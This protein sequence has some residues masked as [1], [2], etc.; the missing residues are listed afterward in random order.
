MPTPR[1]TPPTTAP[2]GPPAGPFNAANIGTASDALVGILSAG[3]HPATRPVPP[4]PGLG[5]GGRNENGGAATD[6]GMRAWWAAERAAG[7]TPSGAELD[8]VCG[9]DPNNGTGRKARARF[10]REEAA[11]RFHA[12]TTPPPGLPQAPRDPVPVPTIAA[13]PAADAPAPDPHPGPA[14]AA[15]AAP[16]RRGPA[17]APAGT[18]RPPR[19]A[20]PP[21]APDP[22]GSPRR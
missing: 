9:R 12:P 15:P 1:G 4:A 19:A 11:G 22:A 2:P 10:L 20:G 3:Q 7:R 8:R 17:P 14:P 6:A 18:T 5:N 21:P 13:A 16:D